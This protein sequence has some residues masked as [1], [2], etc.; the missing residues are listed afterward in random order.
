MPPEN[1]PEGRPFTVEEFL[2][3]V[4]YYDK[5]GKLTDTFFDGAL[6]LPFSRFTYSA[7]YKCA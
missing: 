5:D 6:F 4:G 7:W 1:H 3:Y 2:P